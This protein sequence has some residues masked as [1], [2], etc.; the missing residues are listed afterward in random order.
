MRQ[1]GLP[2]HPQGPVPAPEHRGPGRR[3]P[4]CRGAGTRGAGPLSGAT[5]MLPAQTMFAADVP[6]AHHWNQSVL[7]QPA[8]ALDAAALEQALA[9]LVQRHDALRLRFA[10]SAN[11]WQARFA[12]PSNAPLLAYRRLS[13]LA[14]LPALCDEVQGS[15]D[16]E[17]GPLLRVVLVD[18]PDASQRLLVVI[19]HPAVDGVSWRVLFDELQQAYGQ[20]ATGA[21]PCLR[22]E[23][24][25]GQPGP[26][27]CRPMPSAPERKRNWASGRPTWAAPKSACNGARRA[28]YRQAAHASTRLDKDLTR[29]LLQDAPAAYRTRINDLLLTALAR[30]LCRWTGHASALVQLEGHGGTACPTARTSA[31]PWAGSPVSSPCTC[32]RRTTWPGRSSG[33]RKTCAACRTTASASPPCAIWGRRDAGADGGPAAAGRHLQLPRAARWQLRRRGRPVRSGAGAG[34]AGAEPGG[35]AAHAWC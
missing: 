18:L 27:G 28:T 9:A 5:A 4:P 19:H 16:L 25:V 21:T 35:A 13:D 26:S 20:A 8:Q 31:R 3:R 17:H 2:D 23:E 6:D 7:L 14:Q 33:S 15:L 1:Q 11:G 29:R 22:A 10:R 12:A 32:T 24:R 34:R 30:V